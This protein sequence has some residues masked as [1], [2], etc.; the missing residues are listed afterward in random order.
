MEILLLVLIVCLGMTIGAIGILM[1]S[2]C[3]FIRAKE[4]KISHEKD[5]YKKTWMRAKGAIVMPEDEADVVRNEVI[6]KNNREGKDTPIK[7]LL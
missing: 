5:P 4:T 6:E 1:A 2:F 7:E 3:C